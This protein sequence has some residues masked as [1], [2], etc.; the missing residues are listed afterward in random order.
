MVWKKSWYIWI[1]QKQ[2]SNMA[3]EMWKLY[4]TFHAYE[5]LSILARIKNVSV[6]NHSSNSFVD[7]FRRPNK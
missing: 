4:E 6:E 5:Q 7:A 2:K 3:F 1:I